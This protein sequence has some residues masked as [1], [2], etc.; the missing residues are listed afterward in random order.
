MAAYKQTIIELVA[1][2]LCAD[3]GL[4]S[5]GLRYESAAFL[6]WLQDEM[7]FASFKQACLA[8]SVELDDYNRCFANKE[9]KI[10]NFLLQEDTLQQIAV[11][12]VQNKPLE[13]SLLY[14]TLQNMFGLSREDTME[15]IT[16]TGSAINGKYAPFLAVREYEHLLKTNENDSLK[17]RTTLY[18][19]IA[20]KE[21][22]RLQSKL[23]GSII[24]DSK[25]VLETIILTIELACYDLS[26]FWNKEI[27]FIIDGSMQR[28][29]LPEV[30][31]NYY[32]K[33][34]Y[35][36][37]L[38]NRSDDPVQYKRD[39]MSTIEPFLAILQQEKTKEENGFFSK[40][41]SKHYQ[42]HIVGAGFLYHLPQH[43]H[44]VA[45]SQ[46]LKKEDQPSVGSVAPP[47]PKGSAPNIKLDKRYQLR[48][49]K[50]ASQPDAESTLSFEKEL[51]ETIE[52]WK[53]NKSQ[54]LVQDPNQGNSIS[55][56][57]SAQKSSPQTPRVSTTQSNPIGNSCRSSSEKAADKSKEGISSS[58]SRAQPIWLTVLDAMPEDTS[59][60]R[61]GYLLVNTP[62]KTL[63][64]IGSGVLTLVTIKEEGPLNEMLQNGVATRLQ[65]L[66][67]EYHSDWVEIPELWR[68]LPLTP[69]NKIMALAVID[70][71]LHC[72]IRLLNGN[73]IEFILEK[74][75]CSG[76][77]LAK[78]KE[79]TQTV[80]Q[81]IRTKI[82]DE[83][84]LFPIA[85]AP[86]EMRSL[87]QSI[88][89]PVSVAPKPFTP[90]R[91]AFHPSPVNSDVKPPPMKN[92][93]SVQLPQEKV[94]EK[95]M[96]P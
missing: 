1:K 90:N 14:C 19:N 53:K 11:R 54:P 45:E 80:L 96:Y 52:A 16:I 29:N 79:N 8:N 27:N 57:S 68:K 9:R 82:K 20:L 84:L 36:L 59:K 31:Y 55:T 12:L 85:L 94:G 40:N 35:L 89:Q 58:P 62:A 81:D 5:A 48:F 66:E 24:A 43:I 42:W 95:N 86:Q 17:I 6:K 37:D 91:M 2:Q 49:H 64:S 7:K 70:D 83:H 73:T 34:K 30:L 60:I 32:L 33:L 26:S 77:N 63:Y 47:P 72:K 41:L 25:C 76:E 78:I 13:D 18:Y 23:T 61:S 92:R 50:S 65:R 21:I 69:E 93:S 38:A 10:L 88:G 56:S 74:V 15:I 51:R 46:T 4:R 39:F 28:N 75:D 67:K 71:K 22:D 87:Q 44:E 3:K